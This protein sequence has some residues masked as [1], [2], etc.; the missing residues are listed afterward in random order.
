MRRRARLITTIAVLATAGILGCQGGTGG[1]RRSAAKP[2]PSLAAADEGG[3]GFVVSKP[4]PAEISVVDRH[5]LFSKPR[6]VYNNA[7]SNKIVKV[8]G[9]TI[10]GVPM[11]IAGE[12]RQ[13]LVGTP[14]TPAPAF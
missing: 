12:I 7:G 14:Q 6:E 2:E 4:P 3:S 10:V 8:A 11:G 9:A 13:I 5:P 1:Y